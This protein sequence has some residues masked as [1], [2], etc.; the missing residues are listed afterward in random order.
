MQQRLVLYHPSHVATLHRVLAECRAE[1]NA[2]T[3]EHLCRQADLNAEVHRLRAEVAELRD[4]LTL[5]TALRREEVERDVADLRHQL[6]TLLA[7]IQRRDPSQ[8]LH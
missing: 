2:Q 8:P 3:F 4:V 1:L 6:E 7:R 5:L